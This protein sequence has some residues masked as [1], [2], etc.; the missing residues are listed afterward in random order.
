[1]AW[2][3]HTRNSGCVKLPLHFIY[4]FKMF[5]YYYLSPERLRIQDC[6]KTILYNNDYTKRYKMLK[7]NLQRPDPPPVVYFLFAHAQAGQKVLW[8]GCFA[9]PT[10]MQ[11]CRNPPPRLLGGCS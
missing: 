5:L 11:E 10:E 2:Q 6:V 8:T 4:V 9:A 1:M 7:T 3:S